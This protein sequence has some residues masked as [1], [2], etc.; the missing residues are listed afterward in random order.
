MAELTLAYV[1]DANKKWQKFV[2]IYK[3]IPGADKLFQNTV[4]K[5]KLVA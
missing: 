2:S 5:L 4:I 1:V 3:T